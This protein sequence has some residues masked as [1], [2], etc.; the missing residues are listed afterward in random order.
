MRDG[1]KAAEMLGFSK[2][3]GG[4]IRPSDKKPGIPGV[5]GLKAP[6]SKVIR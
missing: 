3:E 5:G 1:V 6:E 4:V 2:H